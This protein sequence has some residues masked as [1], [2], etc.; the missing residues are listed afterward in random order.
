MHTACMNTACMLGLCLPACKAISTVFVIRLPLHRPILPQS[1]AR[2][3]LFLMAHHTRPR[4]CTH[5][6]IP[7]ARTRHTGK[8]NSPSAHALAPTPER[9]HPYVHACLRP[10]LS[11]CAR[12]G[13]LACTHIS[14]MGAPESA[15]ACGHVGALTCMPT[16]CANPPTPA[17]HPLPDPHRLTSRRPWSPASTYAHVCTSMA[18]E[19]T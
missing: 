11:D 2:C 6:R 13:T 9:L 12:A 10:R 19:T 8:R 18:G 14:P 1:F 3:W 17:A 15:H 16:L 5:A 4:I 7:Y